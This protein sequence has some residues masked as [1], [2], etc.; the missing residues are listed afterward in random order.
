MHMYQQTKTQ[1]L[2][3]QFHKQDSTVVASCKKQEKKGFEQILQMIPSCAM[4]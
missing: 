1:R 2:K 4:V 3:V